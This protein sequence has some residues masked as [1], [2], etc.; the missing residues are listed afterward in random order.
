[1]QSK[2]SYTIGKY[3]DTGYYLGEKLDGDNI[4]PEEFEENRQSEIRSIIDGVLAQFDK[5]ENK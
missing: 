4:N 5:V 3:V 1:M 2:F